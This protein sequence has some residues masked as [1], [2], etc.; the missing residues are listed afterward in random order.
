MCPICDCQNVK[1]SKKRGTHRCYTCGF[2]ATP[3]KY[4]RWFDGE[5]PLDENELGLISRQHSP[6][7]L[8]VQR[9]LATISQ[10]KKEI[11]GWRNHLDP[12]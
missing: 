9:L 5:L 1:Y 2:E 3:E 4:E 6:S 10:Q 12:D 11:E 8:T 7:R